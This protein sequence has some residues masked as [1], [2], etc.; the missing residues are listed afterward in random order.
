[1][2][3]VPVTSERGPRRLLICGTR[4]VAIE[5]ADVASDIPDIVVEGFVENMDPAKA[6]QTLEGLPIHWVDDIAHLASTHVA[7]CAIATTQRHRFTTQMEEIGFRFTTVVHPTARVSSRAQLGEGTIVN[8]GVLIGAHTVVGRH[9]FFNRGAIVGH[10]TVIGDFVSV[11]PGANI[12]GNV[13]VG[14][15]TFIG[16]GS[17]VINNLSIGSESLIAAGALVTKD[18][19][20]NVQMM[21]AP[22]K[23]TREN[24]TGF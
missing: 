18:V 4:S 21:G 23:I 5:I 1:M 15:R 3:G 12:A 8:A 20:S 11:M 14:D 13:S 22:A 16:M 9:C 10:H 6:G 7:V 24:I 2:T 19:P 17:I